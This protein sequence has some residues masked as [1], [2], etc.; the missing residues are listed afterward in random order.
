MIT[1]DTIVQVANEVDRFISNQLEYTEITAIDLSA[2][3]HTRLRMINA[4]EETEKDYDELL[5]H[6]NSQT[7]V[8]SKNIH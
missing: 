4:L 2:I 1:N 3:I 8:T 7:V 5:D 6:F